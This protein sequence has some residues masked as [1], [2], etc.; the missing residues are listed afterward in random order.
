MKFKVLFLLL[1]ISSN[2]YAQVKSTSG[3]LPNEYTC[4]Q[5]S[6]KVDVKEQEVISKKQNSLIK[7]LDVK[8]IVVKNYNPLFFKSI[9]KTLKKIKYKFNSAIM[10]QSYSEYDMKGDLK[11]IYQEGLFENAELKE[12][13]Y[14]YSPKNTVEEKKVKHTIFP[15]SELKEDFYQNFGEDKKNGIISSK[16]YSFVYDSVNRI[17]RINISENE[18]KITESYQYSFDKVV[19]VKTNLKGDVFERRE[20]YFKNDTIKEIRKFSIENQPEF[21]STMENS[22]VDEL[23]FNANEKLLKK[24]SLKSRK[25]LDSFTDKEYVSKSRKVNF[26]KYEK[27]FLRE[28]QEEYSTMYPEHKIKNSCSCNVEYIYNKYGLIDKI[29][30]EVSTSGSKVKPIATTTFEY[31]FYNK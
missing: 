15:R 9:K 27:G 20:E 23:F 18:S 10:Y 4:F 21:S 11:K 31:E 3:F 6:I 29:I 16:V 19:I 12:F 28:R 5:N 17:K 24:V 1:I 13:L 2:F 25:V 26:Y 22:S 30:N 7:L 14:K 8:T